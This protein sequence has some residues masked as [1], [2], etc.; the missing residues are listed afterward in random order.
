MDK[1]P[2]LVVSDHYIIN[3]KS[4]F[5]VPNHGVLNVSN[6]LCFDILTPNPNLCMNCMLVAFYFSVFECMPTL[7]GGVPSMNLSSVRGS[8]PDVE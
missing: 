7:G 5:P 3:K 8:S 1:Y 2:F 6:D 4:T